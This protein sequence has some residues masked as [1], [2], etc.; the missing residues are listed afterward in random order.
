MCIGI[1]KLQN[2]GN[3]CNKFFRKSKNLRQLLY[4]CGDGQGVKTMLKFRRAQARREFP[5][6]RYRNIARFLAHYYGKGIRGLGYS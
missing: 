3:F 5:A 1:A 2:I 6:V 4:L